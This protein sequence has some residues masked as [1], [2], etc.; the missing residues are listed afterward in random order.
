[1]ASLEAPCAVVSTLRGIP[2][3]EL[4]TWLSYHLGECRF[5]RVYLFFDDPAELAESQDV[6]SHWGPQVV[7][8]AADAQLHEEYKSCTRFEALRAHLGEDWLARQELHV[9]LAMRRAELEGCGWLLHIDLDELFLLPGGMTAPAHFAG[10]APD[11]CTIAYLNHEGV[12]ELDGSCA[13]EAGALLEANRFD[14]VSLFRRNPHCFAAGQGLD[15]LL[16]GGED[17]DGNIWAQCGRSKWQRGLDEFA[18]AVGD[19]ADVTPSQASVAS[20][21]SF[22]FWVQRA[23]QHLGCGQY[24]LAYANGKSAVRLSSGASPNGVHRFGTQDLRRYWN[25]QEAAVLHYAH[26]S[27]STVTAKL[28]RLRNSTGVWW[29]SFALYTKGRE[30]DD[31]QLEDLYREVIALE[32]SAEARR[33]VDSGICFRFRIA[34]RHSLSWSSGQDPSSRGAE[35]APDIAGCPEAPPLDAQGGPG[36]VLPLTISESWRLLTS[37]ALVDGWQ[38]AFAA[39]G[40]LIEKQVLPSALCDALVARLDA[41]LAGEFD[42]GQVPDKM[43]RVEHPQVDVEARSDAQQSRKKRIQVQQV[44]NA[45]K[46]DRLFNAVVHSDELGKLVAAVAGWPSGAR[47]LQDQ[48]W[49]KPPGSG[50]LAF[51][52]DTA[53]MGMGVHT[54][55]LALDDLTHDMGPLEYAR[56]SHLWTTTEA[57]QIPNLYAKDPRYVLRAAAKNCRSKV[58]L[59]PVIVQRGGGSIHNGLTYHGSDANRAD[60]VRRGLG[61]HFVARDGLPDAPTAFARSIRGIPETDKR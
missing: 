44:V 28:R 60:R 35:E 45:W 31:R 55:W 22:A 12:P 13:R 58:D 23:K 46:G 26:G 21:R 49:C 52:R 1:M 27:T 42:T 41:M 33:Q 16:L 2:K 32:D 61:I 25:P 30:L 57:A 9:E 8:I 14:A 34:A 56:G 47:V 39:D 48:V 51:H 17:T 15:D 7:S 19:G 20:R 50:T 40:F 4:S 38:A 43:P 18:K 36:L 24:F 10:V 11:R 29:Q 54:M 53:Y 37:G 5:S 6:L 59:V 3:A